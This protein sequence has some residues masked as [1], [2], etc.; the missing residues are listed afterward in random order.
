[1]AQDLQ[2]GNGSRR[3]RRWPPAWDVEDAPTGHASEVVVRSEVALE[4]K[5]GEFRALLH[6]ALSG[7]PPEVPVHGAQAHPGQAPPH[8]LVH[9]R[10]RGVRVGGADY[11]E[12]HPPRSG[13]AQAAGPQG[14]ARRAG[15]GAGGAE[16]F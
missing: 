15:V 1:M 11:F 6:E 8:R 12:N 13:E 16:T 5:P 14:I 3:R 4:A 10:G 7:Q 2:P 9:E